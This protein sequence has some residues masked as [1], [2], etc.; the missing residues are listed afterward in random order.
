MLIPRE[1]LKIISTVLDPEALQSSDTCPLT[2][3]CSANIFRLKGQIPSQIIDGSTYECPGD[4]KRYKG[5]SGLY[6]GILPARPLEAG[7]PRV[8]THTPFQV[9]VNLGNRLIEW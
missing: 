5:L 1:P 3:G 8:V 2:L 9:L 6:G 4:C 7:A